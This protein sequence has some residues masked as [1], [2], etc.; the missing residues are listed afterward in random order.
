MY[1]PGIDVSTGFVV[2]ILGVISPSS[3]SVAVAAKEMLVPDAKK[4]PSEGDVTVRVGAVLPIA[5]LY[6]RSDQQI[7]ARSERPCH[8][9]RWSA[10]GIK[11]LSEQSV[12]GIL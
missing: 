8:I 4:L 1:V 3:A 12:R 5:V 7:S 2:T 9:S 10:T 6:G 11:C